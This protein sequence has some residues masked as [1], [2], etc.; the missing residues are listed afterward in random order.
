MK[1]FRIPEQEGGIPPEPN[2]ERIPV[3]INKKTTILVKKKDAI[4]KNMLIDS[5]TEKYQLQG[6]F[7]GTN[8]QYEYNK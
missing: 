2:I 4:Q 6:T 7:L 3:K 8:I 1:T 5:R